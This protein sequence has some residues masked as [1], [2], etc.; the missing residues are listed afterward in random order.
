MDL[1][2]VHDDYFAFAAKRRFIDVL[3]EDTGSGI[4]EALREKILTPFFTTKK[5]TC[6]AHRGLS[7][8]LARN[9]VRLM[10]GDFVLD[11]QLT[12]TTF[13]LRFEVFLKPET[14]P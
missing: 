2:S 6:D 7:L 13:R 12:P 9:A 4:P 1:Q 8:A 10:G 5:P 14:G 3:V 11:D